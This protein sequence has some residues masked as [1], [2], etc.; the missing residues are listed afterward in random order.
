[1]FTPLKVVKRMNTAI[2]QSLRLP[3]NHTWQDFV[4]TKWLEI[5]C[6]EGPFIT[7]RYNPT[8]NTRAIIKPEN[9]VGFLDL[10]LQSVN[11]NT[12]SR[13]EWLQYAEIALK[14]SYGYEWQGDNLLIARENILLTLN[15]FYSDFCA[16]KLRL[17]SKQSLSTQQLE[18]FAE[19]IS[20]NFFQ[21]DGIRYVIPMSCKH[22]THVIP[23]ELTLFGE[24]PDRVEKYECEGCK[25]NRPDRHNGKY[26]RI[27]DWDTGKAI[28][29]V[30]LVLS[31][32]TNA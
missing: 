28:R 6:G 23:G 4:K 17:K 16:R 32:K 31:N 5:T 29:F 24:T 22:E 26:V 1:V 8:A 27:M 2:L 19:I 15:D 14:S 25:Y 7:T 21:M 13:E 10:K 9:R 3:K 20:W 30:D 12:Q 18:H 11:A